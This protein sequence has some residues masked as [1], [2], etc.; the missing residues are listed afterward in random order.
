MKKS[1]FISGLLVAMVACGGGSGDGETPPTSEY[2]FEITGPADNTARVGESIGLV[3]IAP[4]SDIS[5]IQWQ[6]IS[7][8]NIDFLGANRKVI[9]FDIPQIGTYDFRVTFKDSDGG[10]RTTDYT[11][12]ATDN[13]PVYINARLDHEANSQSKMSLVA[14]DN[15]PGTITDVQWTQVSGPNATIDATDELIIYFTA[16]TVTTDQLLE[17]EVTASDDQGN[18]DTDSI[19]ILLEQESI[20]SE[21]LFTDGRFADISLADVYAYNK[22]SIYADDLEYCIYSNSTTEYCNL[23]RLPFLGTVNA[24]PSIDQVMDRVLVSHDWMG[25]RFRDFLEQVD[26]SGD[27]RSLLGSTRAIVISYDIKPSFFWSG[28]GAIYLDGKYFWATPEERDTLNITPDFRSDFD[29]DLQ[30]RDPWRIVKDNDYAY[31]NPELSSREP[32][33]LVDSAAYTSRVLYHELAHSSDFFPPR[34]WSSAQD[35]DYPWTYSTL[36]NPDSTALASN[37]RLTSQEM[38]E[39]G[40]VMFHGATATQT[41]MDYTPAQVSDFFFP[42]NATNTYNFSTIREDYAMLAEEYMMSYRFG[43]QYDQ[44]ITGLA[45][46]Y[47]VST[48]E[49][50]RVGHSRIIPRAE[51]VI[52]RILPNV[53][54]VAASASLS[55]PITLTSGVSWLDSIVSPTSAKQMASKQRLA[56]FTDFEEFRHGEHGLV[57]RHP[58]FSK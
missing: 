3:L 54:I 25:A 1:L 50:G 35:S 23:G 11:F 15:F 7:G 20:N 44:G 32:R 33:T 19:Y 47:I 28:T 30:I 57:I 13:E 6:Q 51:F 55:A 46:D 10:S 45:P 40:E 43:V 2:M 34:V 48:A 41:Q 53:D 39:L 36:N 38:Y 24:S 4:E 42:D 26:V 27:I 17:F 8:P 29:K 52:Q 56:R 21:S 49:R 16:P 12:S 58:N 14:Y 5:E 31:Y 37:Y 9:G 18:Q 22:S